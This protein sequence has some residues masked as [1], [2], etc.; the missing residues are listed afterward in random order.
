MTR[1]RFDD[2]STEFGLWLRGDKEKFKEKTGFDMVTDVSSIASRPSNAVFTPVIQ[3]RGYAGHNL[4]YVWF[5]YTENK[6]ML[7]EEK[8]H[9]AKQKKSQRIVHG[10]V[11]TA[12]KFACDNNCTFLNKQAEVK[13]KYFGY[14]I[15]IFQKTNPEDG[16]IKID[17][18]KVTIDQLLAFLRF[19]WMPS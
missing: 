17:G 1:K 16:W 19:E 2:Y 15:I 8:R 10:L 3:S 5:C 9:K 7:V 6:L 11:D 14:H 12:F 18:V 13:I 4:D